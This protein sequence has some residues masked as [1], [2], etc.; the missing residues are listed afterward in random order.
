[1]GWGEQ[2]IGCGQGFERPS[3]SDEFALPLHQ[4]VVPSGGAGGWQSRC[5]VEGDCPRRRRAGYS[6]QLT[7]WL[8]SAGA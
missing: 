2:R 8:C 1:M 4:D 5:R 3:G 7:V 6:H